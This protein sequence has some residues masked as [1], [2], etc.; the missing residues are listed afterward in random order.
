MSE[1]TTSA[2]V[3]RAKDDNVSIQVQNNTHW[4]NNTGVRIFLI[5]RST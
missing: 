4:A 2:T 1:G 3:Y 5:Y